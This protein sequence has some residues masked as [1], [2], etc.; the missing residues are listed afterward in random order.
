MWATHLK[1]LGEVSVAKECL[2][3]GMG[4]H[5]NRCQPQSVTGSSDVGKKYEGRYAL[6]TGQHSEWLARASRSRH[7]FLR[8]KVK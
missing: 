7:N 3:W 8:N 4:V 5:L 2:Y 6:P 1:R